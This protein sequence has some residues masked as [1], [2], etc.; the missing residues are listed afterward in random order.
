MR[1]VAGVERLDETRGERMAR[2]VFW[3][4]IALSWVAA[5]AFMWEGMSRVPSAERL[6]ESRLVTI[7]T[8]RTFLTAAIF[9]G[10]EVALVLAALWP[11]KPDFYAARMGVTALALITWFIMTTPMDVSRMDWIHRRWLAFMV[12]LITITLVILLVYRLWRRLGEGRRTRQGRLP[13]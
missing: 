1:A 4:V 13:G 12:A 5:V 9:S 8:P 11:W 2:L 6:E 7:P 3:I 10:M